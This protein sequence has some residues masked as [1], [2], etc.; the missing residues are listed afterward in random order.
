MHGGWYIAPMP[1]VIHNLYSVALLR[2]SGSF[3]TLRLGGSFLQFYWNTG[4]FNLTHYL[5]SLNQECSI[6]L[7]LPPHFDLFGPEDSERASVVNVG[8]S[9]RGNFLHELYSPIRAE[10]TDKPTT[11][12]SQVSK[13]LKRKWSPYAT[14]VH[15][16]ATPDGSPP[17]PPPRRTQ[18]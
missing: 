6:N 14:S 1:H 15:Y 5:S 3:V 16:Q 2:P 17:L 12:K 9:K 11:S 10:W 18:T 7:D 13:P 8:N 4:Y